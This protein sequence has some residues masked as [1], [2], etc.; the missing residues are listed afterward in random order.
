M[1]D[2]ANELLRIN[3]PRT[4]VNKGKEKGRNYYTPA[5]DGSVARYYRRA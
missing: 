4:P 5:L 3:L 2:P 1:Q